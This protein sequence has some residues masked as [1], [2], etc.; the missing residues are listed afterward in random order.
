MSITARIINNDENN[1]YFTVPEDAEQLKQLSAFINTHTAQKTV[2]T[3]NGITILDGG[4]FG[5]DEQCAPRDVIHVNVKHHKADSMETEETEW[6]NLL[7]IYARGVAI[8]NQLKETPH[9]E[10]DNLSVDNPQDIQETVQLLE[11]LNG[12]RYTAESTENGYIIFFPGTYTAPSYAAPALV[13]KYGSAM[14]LVHDK[15]RNQTY[16][17][18]ATDLLNPPDGDHVSKR[19]MEEFTTVREVMVEK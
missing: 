5:G 17:R 16:M 15:Q 12:V 19:V 14:I 11:K 3:D 7:I 18:D 4:E 1:L 6:D 10:N 2:A 8:E 13:F 9:L